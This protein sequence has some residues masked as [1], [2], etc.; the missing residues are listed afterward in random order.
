MSGATESNVARLRDLLALPH[1]DPARVA[2]IV[3]YLGRSTPAEWPQPVRSLMALPGAADR[4]GS[5]LA[6]ALET[7]AAGERLP[8]ELAA[9]LR[10][11]AERAP[12]PA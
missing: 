9:N 6:S 2:P 3:A 12:I 8:R 5:L 10:W 7:L 1:L 4:D 11:R